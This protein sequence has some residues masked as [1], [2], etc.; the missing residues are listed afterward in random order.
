MILFRSAFAC[1]S[2]ETCAEAVRDQCPEGGFG[3]RSAA[4]LRGL[5]LSKGMDSFGRFGLILMMQSV[6]SS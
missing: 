3:E 6:H 4:S 5:T 2:L 1:M